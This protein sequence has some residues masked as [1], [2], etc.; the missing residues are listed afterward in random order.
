MTATIIIAIIIIIT[1]TNI[2]VIII[3]LIVTIII[4]ISRQLVIGCSASVEHCCVPLQADSDP[5]HAQE[6]S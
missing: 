1:S 5:E 4:I 6:T 2:V 3:N